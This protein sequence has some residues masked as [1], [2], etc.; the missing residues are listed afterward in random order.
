MLPQTKQLLQNTGL[1]DKLLAES[2][3]SLM[4]ML[5][6]KLEERLLTVVVDSLPKEKMSEF[7]EKLKNNDGDL[8]TYLQTN[9]P[10]YPIVLK[11]ELK[12]FTAEVKKAL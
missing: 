6:D 2:R 1:A 4:E 10:N 5:G 12:K 9:V 3:D 7:E 8:T 11:E